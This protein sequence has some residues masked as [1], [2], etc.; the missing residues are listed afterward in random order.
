MRIAVQAPAVA[1]DYNLHMEGVGK[2][3]ILLSL[4]VRRG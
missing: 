2:V 1:Q 3:D 4:T